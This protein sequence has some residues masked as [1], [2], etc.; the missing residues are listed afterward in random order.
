[1][2]VMT[3][4]NWSAVALTEARAVV[5]E[6]EPPTQWLDTRIQPLV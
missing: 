6:S 1:M 5:D 2:P 3:D 4:H